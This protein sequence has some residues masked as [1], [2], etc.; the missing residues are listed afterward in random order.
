MRIV[1]DRIAD[2]DQGPDRLPSIRFVG[3]DRADG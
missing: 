3:I 1:D 2:H